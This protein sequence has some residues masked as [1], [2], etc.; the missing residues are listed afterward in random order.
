MDYTIK[1]LAKI[2]GVS[3]RTLR[4][5]DEIGLLV[6]ARKSSNGYRIYGQKEVDLLQQILFY[7]ELDMPL[8]DIKSIV[9]SDDFDREAALRSH[10]KVLKKKRDRL[11]TLILNLEK[12]I[13]YVKGEIVM[14]DT[15]KFEGFKQK[16]I[17]ENEKQYGAEIR[18]KY[19][20]AAVMASN[21][22]LMGMTKE[23]YMEAEKLSSEINETL[24]AAVE[25]GD[26]AGELAQK[27]CAAHKK[28]LSYFWPSY[29]KEAHAGLG[30]M[31]AE[32]PR[33]TAYYDK[34]APGCA[35]FFRDALQIYC[36][37]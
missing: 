14:N 21:A 11:D 30:R 9:L 33:F 35:K 5:Y 12:T 18:E 3:T 32:D 2:T 34:I 29:S 7:R 23:Q 27:A 13:K 10:L 16:L 22:K 6:P 28:W 4:F 26:P 31:Y 8:E 25:Q 36:Q 19:G 37:Q 20:E 17:D 15:E 24:K 1:K